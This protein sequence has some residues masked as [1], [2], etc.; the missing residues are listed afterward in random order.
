MIRLHKIAFRKLIHYPTFWI[1]LGLHLVLLSLII[2]GLE[3]FLASIEMN[4]NKMSTE[5]LRQFGLFAFP[6]VW[7][8]ITYVAGFFKF[9]LALVIIIDVT[10]DISFRTNRQHIIDGLSHLEY[11][12]TKGIVVFWLALVSTII[13]TLIGFY[14]GFSHTSDIASG[15]ILEKFAFIGGYFIE[16]VSYLSFA[17]LVGL[18]VKRSGLAIGLLLLYSWII[19]PLIGFFFP[20]NVR[21]YLPMENLNSLIE[22][23]FQEFFGEVPQDNISAM[24]LIIALVYIAIFNFVSYTMISK[25]DL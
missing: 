16:L 17:L 4:G 11:T 23:P 12:L 8:N 22:L 7:H 2:L 19:E 6:D 14:L 3:G 10:N 15:E 21:V 24:V 25:K 13:L 1:L 5:D 20:E 9:I 18:L